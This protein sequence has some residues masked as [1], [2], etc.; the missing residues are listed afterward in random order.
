MSTNEAL[1]YSQEEW[2]KI[3]HRVFESLP[4]THKSYKTPEP[5][6]VEVA[7][8]IDHTLLK[9]DATPQQIDA[10]CKEARQFQFKVSPYE[11]YNVVLQKVKS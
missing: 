5:G 3:I 2:A 11:S 6:S 4:S 7:E 8:L 1:K 9:T 10:I